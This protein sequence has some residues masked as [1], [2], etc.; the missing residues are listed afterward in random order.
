MRLRHLSLFL[1]LG[2][3]GGY[4]VLAAPAPNP[5][6]WARGW[7]EIPDKG[8]KFTRFTDVLTIEVPDNEHYQTRFR[9]ALDIPCLL[10]TVEG[11]FVVEVR[12][13]GISD[14]SAPARGQV[15]TSTGSIPLNPYVVAG[16]LLTTT[17]RGP[18][19]KAGLYMQ[20]G[21]EKECSE[22]TVEARAS[23]VVFGQKPKQ[24]VFHVFD[25]E[26]N[27]LRLRRQGANFAVS[28]SVDGKKWVDIEAHKADLPAK[29]KLGVFANSDSST[30]FKPRFDKFKLTLMGPKG[31]A[32]T[33]RTP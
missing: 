24:R 29:L 22:G 30:P 8:C 15:L 1:F 17:D 3:V 32:A 10:R 14:P 23:L 33:R 9:P 4:A 31:G 16:I 21:R 20:W 7:Q 27:Y 28:L 6:P 25:K 18:V 11:D 2:L 19:E 13:D 26:G 12:V 5:G